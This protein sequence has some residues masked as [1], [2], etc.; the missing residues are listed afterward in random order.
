MCTH[1]SSKRAVHGSPKKQGCAQVSALGMTDGMF[2]GMVDYRFD[3]A[4]NA[5]FQIT[6]GG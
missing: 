2:D 1:M 3:G 5:M 4:S 6:P